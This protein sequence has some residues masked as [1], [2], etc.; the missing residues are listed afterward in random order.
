MMERILSDSAKVDALSVITF[1]YFN[2]IGADPKL[3]CGPPTSSTTVLGRLLHAFHA[4][5]PFHVTGT[6]WSTPDGS[7]VRDY[8]HVWDVALAHVAALKRFDEVMSTAPSRFQ[9][10]NVGT[11][12]AWSVYELVRVFEDLVGCA[13]DMSPAPARLADVKGCAA[14]IERAAELL[15][16]SPSRT[17][18]DAVRDTL[19]WYEAVAK[20]GENVASPDGLENVPFDR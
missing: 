13:V 4:N 2:P 1:R 16:W 17:L 12:R 6:D 3:R 11:G 9:I 15:G 19:A 20:R 7:A 8:V 18:A 10:I 5:E 14:N